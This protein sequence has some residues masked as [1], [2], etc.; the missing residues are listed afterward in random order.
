MAYDFDQLFSETPHPSEPA[1]QPAGY[2]FDALFSEKADRV[3][4]ETSLYEAS[5]SHPDQ[6]AERRKLGKQLETYLGDTTPPAIIDIHDAQRRVRVAEADH[7][8]RASPRTSAFLSAPENARIALDDAKTLAQIET[9]TEFLRDAGKMAV[10][11]VAYEAPAGLAGIVAAPFDIIEKGLRSAGVSESVL[12]YGP[13]SGFR[14]LAG[15]AKFSAD[16]ALPIGDYQDPYAKAALSGFASLGQNLAT[17]PAGVLRSPEFA[18]GLMSLMAGGEPYQESSKGGEDPIRGLLRAVPDM[19]FEYGGEKFAIK[20]LF[21]NKAFKE[22]FGKQAAKF[23][24]QDQL[25]EQATTVGQN[26]SQ[27]MIENP[28]KGVGQFVD[29]MPAAFRDTLVASLIGGGGQLAIVRGLSAVLKQEESAAAVERDAGK[30][31][32]LFSLID[33]SLTKGRDPDTF[34][35]FFQSVSEDAAVYVDRATLRDVLYKSGL[36]ESAIPSLASQPETDVTGVGAEVPVKELVSALAGTGAETELI[37]HIRMTPDSSTLFETQENGMKALEIFRAEAAKIMQ[38][39]KTTDAF[40]ASAAAVRDDFI[41]QLETAS[42]FQKTHNQGF[43]DLATAFYTT[44]AS[45]LG[46]TPTQF[47]DGWTDAAGTLHKGYRLKIG[48]GAQ[49]TTGNATFSQGEPD[50]SG[51]IDEA[52]GLPLNKDGTVTVYHHTS[53]ANAEEIRR[54][55]KLQ[56]AGEPDLYFTTTADT[57]TGYGD[58]AIPFRVK[59]ERLLLDDEF[60]DGRKDFRVETKR[61]D[62]ARRVRFLPDGEGVLLQSGKINADTPEFRKWFGDSVITDNGKPM[63][64]GGKPLVVYHGTPGEEFTEFDIPYGGVYLTPTEALAGRYE[65][66]N[67]TVIPVYLKAEN[68]LNAQELDAR[69]L[70]V[71]KDIENDVFGEDDEKI[72]DAIHE[73]M[74]EVESKGGDVVAW[75]LTYQGKT[76]EVK[77]DPDLFSADEFLDSFGIEPKKKRLI[78][79]DGSEPLSE[80]IKWGNLIFLGRDIQDQVIEAIHDAGYDAVLMPDFHG[81]GEGE[82]AFVAFRPEQIKSATGNRGTFDPNDPNI[83]H[84]DAKDPRASF[85]PKTLD[86]NLLAGADLSSLG[87]ELGHFFLTVYSDLASQPDAPAEIVA[88]MAALLKWFDP[89]LTLDQWNGMSTDQQRAYHE[90][91]AESFEAYLFTGKAPTAELQG[92]FNKL[93]KW[94]MSVYRTMIDFVKQNPGAKINPEVSAVFDRMLATDAEIAAAEEARAYSQLFKDAVEA[95]MSTEDFA[96]YLELPKES[97]AQAEE[98]LRVLGLR[99]MRWIRNFKNATIAEL[100]QE[101]K[102]RRAEMMIESRREVLTTPL[103]RAWSFLTG[104]GHLVDDVDLASWRDENKAWSKDYDQAEAE[105]RQAAEI[106]VW[107]AAPEFLKKHRKQDSRDADFRRV[108]K[109][110]STDVEKLVEERIGQWEQSHPQPAKPGSQKAKKEKRSA[111]VDPTIDSLFE[112]IAKLGGIDRNE[113][114]GTWGTDPA[115]KPSSGLFGK[116]VWRKEKGHSIDAMAELLGQYGYLTP[117]DHGKAD[118][119]QFEEAWRSEVSGEPHYSAA[120]DPSNFVEPPRAGEFADLSQLESARFDRASLRESGIPM[121]ILDHLEVLGMVSNDGIHQDLIAG[122]F[123]FPSGE[124]LIRTLAIADTPKDAIEA[125]TDEKMLAQYGSLATPQAIEQAADEAIHNDVR[126]RLVATE[127]NALDKSIGAPSLLMKAAKEYARTIVATKSLKTLKP[128]LFAAEE[129]RSAKKAKAAL[130]KGDRNE[131]AKHKRAELLNHAAVKEAYAGLKEIEKTVERFKK[132]AGYKD[133]DSSAKTRDMDLVN[134]VRFVLAQYGIGRHGEK[135]EAY[136]AIV[137]RM[138]ANTGMVL[139]DL[140]RGAIANP[141]DYRD[142]S[143]EQLRDLSKAVEA[144]WY[145]AKAQRTVTVQGKKADL[146]LIRGEV[147]AKLL[148]SE[149]VEPVGVNH[150]LTKAEQ[151]KV[152][153]AKNVTKIKRIESWIGAKDGLDRFG[154]LRRYLWM[155]INDADNAYSQAKEQKFKELRDLLTPIL[156]DLKVQKIAAPELGYTFGEGSAVGMSELLHALLHTGNESNQRKLLLGREVGFGPDKGKRWADQREDGS[157]DTTRWD[158]F[159]KRLH[160]NGTLTKAHWDF[161]QSVWDYMEA[162]KPMAQQAHKEAYGRYFDEV[163]FHPVQ[164]PF[165]TYKGGYVPATPERDADHATDLRALQEDAATGMIQTLPQPKSGF[166]KGRVEYNTRLELN[167]RALTRHV[168]SVLLF[169]HMSNPIRDVQK[170]LRG[171][172]VLAAM[173]ETDKQA[174][175]YLLVPWLQHAATQTVSYASPSGLDGLRLWSKLRSRTGATFMFANLL[176]TA[177]QIT[178]FGMAALK[179]KP[180]YMLSAAKNN[181]LHPKELA[182]HV[183]SL[184]PYMNTRLKSEV[185]ALADQ[186][187]ELLIAPSRLETAQAWAMRN[188]YFLQMAMDSAMSPIIWQAKYNE[189]METHGDEARAIELADNAVRTTQGSQ[190]AIDVASFEAGSPFFRMFTQFAGWA[191]TM[192]NTMAEE[193]AIAKKLPSKSKAAKRMAMVAILGY[194]S[195]GIVS[196]LIGT[197]FRGGP[198]DEDKDGEYLDDWFATA[199]FDGLVKYPLS[200]VPFAGPALI[201]VFNAF[202]DKPYDDKI[203]GAPAISAIESSAK[204]LRGIWDMAMKEDDPNT[205]KTIRNLGTLI[206]LAVG[207]PVTPA[208]KA[209][210]YLADIGAE[211]VA[212]TSTIDAVRGTITGIASPPSKQ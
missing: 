167:L 168:D 118:L 194:V 49:Q 176:N 129:V 120:V 15:L 158:A 98:L 53:A 191:S 154:P 48:N 195:V 11:G 83:L 143:L 103:Y 186:M 110:E 146:D 199:L 181:L 67:G 4:V 88:D 14:Q 153:F 74:E 31:Q 90:R 132:L 107:E 81:G 164:T 124:D 22:G 72:A 12:K 87:H 136:L 76:I 5:F 70:E 184:S 200:M 33:A 142:L 197:A 9:A 156:A 177:Q 174:L 44:M 8:T 32:E 16:E 163:T 149:R 171:P 84:Q 116:P 205:G 1:A 141:K 111:G 51:E 204:A 212:P 55:G 173:N 183:S 210:G 23:L 7:A 86:L 152:V 13:G 161:V 162:L 20:S 202:N 179:V 211:K 3:P 62:K 42:P 25:G 34:A 46:I 155:T 203:P 79:P 182:N 159:L 201:T 69:D 73:T 108:L 109:R 94:M 93:A 21:N 36:D 147:A 101:A 123:G 56:S 175:N 114:I 134:A 192:A 121:A 139:G 30:L 140:I 151:W 75:K 58:T 187:D 144:M 113:V 150:A 10:R 78:G 119:K 71:L 26:F 63:S 125:R 135:A 126:T 54:T 6:E 115:D 28:D 60:P 189:E 80:L 190:R 35:G 130:A 77:D 19:V 99:D 169:S 117:D 206:G 43:A 91:T 52:T 47:R 41:A 68:P 131:A 2:D 198:G 207:I 24:L 172:E 85:N 89:A 148:E 122:Q 127:L 39:T 100:Q 137:D 196:S 59:P 37:P 193:V 160:D 27:W 106:E 188:A 29:E 170:I 105:I 96:A 128:A 61:A 18:L 65:G 38:E 133:T 82:I 138:D 50:P 97:T 157:L 112:A 102:E 104:K 57:N 209:A 92:L 17:L 208:T 66:E 165:G 145:L 185:S 178:G 166:T 64:E 180:G 40:K 95:G 45:K